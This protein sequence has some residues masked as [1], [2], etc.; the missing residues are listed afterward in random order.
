MDDNL[1]L[2]VA[3]DLGNLGNLHMGHRGAVA[4]GER[5]NEQRLGFG[6]NDQ[7]CT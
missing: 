6:G 7:S 2:G 1:G 4:P 5:A 3:H